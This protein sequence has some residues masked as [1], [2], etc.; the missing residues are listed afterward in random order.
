MKN[1]LIAIGDIHGEIDKLNEL[2]KQLEPIKDDTLV[3]VGDYIDRGRHSKQ[4]I[5]RLISL[6]KE[7]NCIFLKGNHEQMLLKLIETKKERDI[8]FW[9]MNGGSETVESYGNLLEM[10]E[11]HGCFFKTLKPYYLTNKYLFVH[12]GIRPDKP[13]KEQT[14]GDLLW[15]RDDFIDKKHNLKQKVIFGHTAFYNPYVADDKIGIDT[16]CGKEDDAYL[17]ALICDEEYFITSE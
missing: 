17:T 15:I 16:G 9:L 3:F 8:N 10:L 13:I 7:I 6:S 2:L 12:A 4:V 11:L 14:E 1:R 5:E